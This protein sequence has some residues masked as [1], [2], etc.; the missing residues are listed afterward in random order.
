MRL[1]IRNVEVAGRVGLDVRI[2][3]GRI[4]G[5]GARLAGAGPEL[6]GRGGALIPGLCDHHIHL[7]ALAARAE[8]VSLEGVA[9]PAAFAARIAE[10]TASKPPG[11]W[12]R[13][14]GYHEAMAGDLTRARLDALAPRH[15]LRVQH[16]TGSLWI[17]NSL[18]L[19]AL[20]EG[21]DPPS[22]ERDTGRIWRGDA[23]L[24]RRIGADPPPLAPVGARLAACGITALTDA[25][26]TTDDDAA[27]RLAAAHRAGE[28]PQRLTLMSGG[29]LT[30]AADG[31]FAVGPLKVLLDDHALPEFDDFTDRIACARTWDRRVAVHCV[32]AAELAL[33]LAAFTAAGA[34]PGDRI[35]HGGVIP[36]D[37]IG[38]LRDLGL[39]VVTQPAFVRER[40]DRYLRDVAPSDRV[41]L[42][43][44]ASLTA[45][46]VPVA[47]SSDAP[48][49]SPD[50]W[51]GI[52]AAIDR[53]TADGAMLG[54]DERVSPEAALALYL[55]DPAA[56]GRRPRRVE[57]GAPADLC[58]LKAPLRDVLAAPSAEFVAATIIGGAVV[59]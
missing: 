42:Y 56:P 46:G 24:R 39:T 21:G 52:A 22:L 16:Q 34:A 55:D 12:I 45:A 32:T 14:L 8:S 20:G 57:A 7:F 33:T 18:A 6:D 10:A 31:A 35:E 49:A 58:L 50:P 28:L 23:W 37:A 25:S 43:R 27:A 36:P 48:Y 4:A 3:G 19:A 38:Q 59:Q 51:R 5:I 2:E 53:R 44:C 1:L 26:V 29:A 41:D 11:A 47:A 54:A 9:S 17:L 40:G 30:A 13:V 15:R